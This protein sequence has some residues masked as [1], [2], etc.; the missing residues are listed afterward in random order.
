[1]YSD[2]TQVLIQTLISRLRLVL[3]VTVGLDVG[4]T[5]N[6]ARAMGSALLTLLRD[7]FLNQLLQVFLVIGLAASVAF[8]VEDVQLHSVTFRRIQTHRARVAHLQHTFSTPSAHFSTP[9]AHLQHTS[10]H[11]QHTF[12]QIQICMLL[13][14]AASECCA[15]HVCDRRRICIE[16]CIK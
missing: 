11:L 2:R 14:A 13:Y 9:S 16:C 5:D 7:Q 4:T 15:S 1:M 3:R 8:F 6:G 10:A 12:N